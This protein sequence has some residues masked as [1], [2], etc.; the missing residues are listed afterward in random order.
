LITGL[1]PSGFCEPASRSGPD[2][3]IRFVPG[4]TIERL[5]IIMITLQQAARTLSVSLLAMAM[6][7]GTVIVTFFNNDSARQEVSAPASVEPWS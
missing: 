6:A 5:E 7:Y 4:G 1:E 2:F 3:T